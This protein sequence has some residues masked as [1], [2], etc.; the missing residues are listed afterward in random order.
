MNFLEY[1]ENVYLGYRYYETVRDTGGSFKVFNQNGLG[2]N[3]AVQILF[4]FG[5]S[6][7]TDFSQNI[8]AF[9]EQDGC[10]NMTVRV[11]NNGAKSGKDLIVLRPLRMRRRTPYARILLFTFMVYLNTPPFLT[12]RL[13]P[14]S[15]HR[16]II[17]CQMPNPRRPVFGLKDFFIKHCRKS[18]IL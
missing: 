12:E 15:T 8:R 13:K 4:G 2:Y 7:E 17:G 6:Y 18:Q 11:I 9:N 10:I 14:V 5:L 3:E 1:E 16:F